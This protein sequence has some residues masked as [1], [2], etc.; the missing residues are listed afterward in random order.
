MPVKH[1][2]N[3]LT[4]QAPPDTYVGGGGSVDGDGERLHGLRAVR[5]VNQHI[6]RNGAREMNRD[7]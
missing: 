4:P 2:S 5:A 6:H 7:P 3:T 1:M